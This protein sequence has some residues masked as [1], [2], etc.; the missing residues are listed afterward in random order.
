MKR[1][2]GFTLIE[3]LV[4]TLILSLIA[5]SIYSG[6]AQV[7]KAIRTVRIKQNAAALAN[8]QFEIIRN[9]AY[10]DLGIV[11]G[12]PVGVL[13]RKKVIIRD[14]LEFTVTTTVRSVDQPFDG[15]IGDGDLSPAD[16]KF[17]Q[18]DI[19]CP[20]CGE[21]I[22]YFSYAS[23]VAPRS[24]ETAEGNGALFV[25]VFDAD[26]QPLQGAEINII[27]NSFSPEINIDETTNVNGALQIVDAPP[28]TGS[29]QIIVTK[30]GFSTEQTYEIGGADNP[31]PHIPHAHVVEGQVTQISFAI[32]ELGDLTIETTD[33]FCQAISNVDFSLTGSKT[34][35]LERY[36][37]NE[38]HTTGGSGNLS[39]NDIEWD[40]YEITIDDLS[41]QLAGSNPTLPLAVNPGTDQ[42]INLVLVPRDTKALLVQVVDVS[43]GL[44]LSDAEV[45]IDGGSGI[46][47][48]ITGQGFLR[49]TD[50]S[51]GSGQETYNDPEKFGS[52]SNIDFISNPGQITLDAFAGGYV[53]EGELESSIFDIG[54][55]ANFHTLS[56]Q[57]GD[58]PAQTGVDPVR[59]QIATNDVLVD[60][61]TLIPNSWVY[62][63]P[64]G[65]GSTYYTSPDETLN[66]VHDGAQF[67]RYKVFLSTDNTAFT[68]NISDVS[69]TFSS[70]CVPTGEVLFQ[71]LVTDNY[72]ITVSRSGYVTQSINNYVVNEDFQVITI[73]MS[74]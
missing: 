64:D 45:T 4:S 58:Q 55:I 65:S 8:E 62:R 36:K 3:T 39:L 71:N 30:D 21:N 13:P 5:M 15:T 51:D 57:P 33:E 7:T 60:P 41:Y 44:S 48:D 54:T 10:N 34:I 29:Y 74:Q 27:N 32:D 6:F 12:L 23:Q 18:I 40:T 66:S 47:T 26:G 28:A 69:F 46:L 67:F 56:W 1:S 35:G 50:W 43:T 73:I 14:G 9:L 52:E 20:Q 63:G 37:Y 22:G 11:G 68:P 70:N 31:V 49:Q 16:T 53:D 17:V 24:L 42:T 25:R 61:E 59:F 19:S 38:A 2:S 72:D